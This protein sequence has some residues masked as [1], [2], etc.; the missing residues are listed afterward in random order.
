MRLSTGKSAKSPFW[1]LR[2]DQLAFDGHLMV[3]NILNILN[4]LEIFVAE[5]YA[6]FPQGKKLEVVRQLLVTLSQVTASHKSSC[7]LQRNAQLKAQIQAY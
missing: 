2:L 1:P 3:L 7:L 4:Y 5:K 6:H